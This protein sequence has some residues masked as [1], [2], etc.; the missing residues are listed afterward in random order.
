VQVTDV[1]PSAAVV[2]L[3]AIELSVPPST[4]L[5]SPMDNRSQRLVLA[6]TVDEEAVVAVGAPGP[7][8]LVVAL[9][10]AHAASNS[11][12]AAASGSTRW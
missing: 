4:E 8:V 6:D 10:P 12:A 9:G 5:T 1:L 3:R 7:P 11:S 2:L